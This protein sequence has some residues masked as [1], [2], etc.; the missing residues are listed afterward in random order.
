MMAVD[1][2]VTVPAGFTRKVIDTSKIR[3][4]IVNW[5]LDKSGKTQLPFTAPDP[6]MYINLD[7]DNDALILKFQEK[8]IFECR[9]MTDPDLDPDASMKMLRAF[10]EQYVKALNYFKEVQHGTLVVD[11][12]TVVRSLIDA[13]MHTE[14]REQRAAAKGVSADQVKNSQLDYQGANRRTRGYVQAV[15]NIPGVNLFLVHKAS[16]MYG[17]NGQA[18]EGRYKMQGW[19]EVS[20]LV[21]L[22]IHQYKEGPKFMSVIESCGPNPKLVGMPLVN[23]DYPTLRGLLL[24]EG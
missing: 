5:G 13:V 24:G 4:T 19:P 6:I 3:H 1:S 15:N 12:F 21:D 22:T 16:Q 11:T 18:M 10:H 17:D 7:R 8:D 14:A 20:S 2:P 9:V 23:L